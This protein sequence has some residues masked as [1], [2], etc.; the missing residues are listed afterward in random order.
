MI[1]IPN[2]ELT[3]QGDA[4][5]AIICETLFIDIKDNRMV[6]VLWDKTVAIRVESLRNSPLCETL[7]DM[8]H[9]FGEDHFVQAILPAI[10]KL[11]KIHCTDEDYLE[12]FEEC[13]KEVL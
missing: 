5:L 7:Y 1:T 9:I 2:K 6:T 13:F 11:E 12:H 3:P 8:F 4:D 10:L